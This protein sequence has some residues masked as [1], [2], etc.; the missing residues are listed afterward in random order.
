MMLYTLFLHVLDTKTAGN[1]QQDVS[2]Y[3]KNTTEVDAA[4]GRGHW[5]YCV[6][7]IPEFF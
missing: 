5:S 2:Y 6:F 4:G 3:W 7:D 1:L